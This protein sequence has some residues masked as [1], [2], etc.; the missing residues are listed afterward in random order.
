MRGN[1]ISSN[2]NHFLGEDT[3]AVCKERD[4]RKEKSGK[5]N[6]KNRND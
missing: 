5:F 2:Q 4:K 6:L 1:K 3:R